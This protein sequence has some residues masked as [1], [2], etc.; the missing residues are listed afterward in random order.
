MADQDSSNNTN[1]SNNES[2][3]N[4]HHRKKGRGLAR[5][6]REWGKTKLNIEVNDD[7]QPCGGDYQALATQIGYFMKDGHSFPL[8]ETWRDIDLLAVERIWKEIEVINA[9]R[10]YISCYFM[11][12]V[13]L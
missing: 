9:Y 8:T 11:L 10:C 1:S 12:Y 7:W 3:G 6:T 5:K 13:Y 2:S 4:E